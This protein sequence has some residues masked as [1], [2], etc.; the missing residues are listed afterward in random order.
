LNITSILVYIAGIPWQGYFQ[1]VL[2]IKSTKAAQILSTL[3][4]F[5]CIFMAVP[6]AAIGVFAR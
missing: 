1:R 5:G 6:A 2:S 3:S 4:M